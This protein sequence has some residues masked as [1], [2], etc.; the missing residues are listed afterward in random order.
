MIGVLGGTFDPIHFGHLRPALDCL[1]ALGLDEVRLVPLKV[2]VHR[3]QPMA[4]AGVRLAMVQ[5]A[6]SGVSGLV[7]DGRELDRAG[8]SYSYDT[9]ASLRQ[10][11]GP[12]VPICLLVGADAFHGFLTWHRPAE[13]LDLAHLVVMQRPD[14]PEPSD[15]V[16]RRWLSDL[17]C[18]GPQELRRRPVGRILRLPVTQM[19]ISSS[20][21]R[22][23]MRAG[24]S[25]R[26]LLP[27]SVLEMALAA[28]LY[29]GPTARADHDC[30]TPGASRPVQPETE[31]TVCS[32]NN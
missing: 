14:A 28:G 16:L 32:L 7:A 25:P 4:A 29:Q 2:A 27:D 12:R 15:Q 11:L 10:E 6:V 1:Q 23:L 30:L 9:L 13:I 3:P 8:P 26:Y 24:Q 17:G 21:I 20:R 5:A 22:T 19:D 31:E 18:A